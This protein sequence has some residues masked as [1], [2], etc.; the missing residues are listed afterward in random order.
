[1]LVGAL[2]VN[3]SV[4]FVTAVPLPPTCITLW[5]TW[6]TETSLLADSAPIGQVGRKR[7]LSPG[8]GR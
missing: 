7:S 8:A 5:N 1:M 6:L 2:S 4:P 3:P